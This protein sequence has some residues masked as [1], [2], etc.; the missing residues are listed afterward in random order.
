MYDV[1]LLLHSWNRR[2]I[3]ILGITAVLLA[4]NGWRTNRIFSP[5]DNLLGTTFMGALNMQVIFGLILYFFLSPKT[6]YALA[7]FSEAIQDR[8]MRYFAIEHGLVMLLAIILAMIGRT[9]V[10]KTGDDNLKHKRSFIFY[11]IAMFL[12][13]LMVPY[14]NSQQGAPL[15]RF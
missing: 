11:T 15:F 1:L 9:Q 5:L 6:M 4:Y 10:H 14:G 8:H 12:I 3:L 13:L 7:H 2:L